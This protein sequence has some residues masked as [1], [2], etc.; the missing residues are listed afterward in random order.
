MLS[1]VAQFNLELEQIDVKTVFLHTD[2][3]ETIYIE[4]LEG[5]QVQKN[6]DIV[7]LLKKSLYGHIIVTCKWIYKIK[8]GIP[9]DEQIK[10]K[11]RLFVKGLT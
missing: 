11:A 8:R 7:C 6:K 2:L 9:E 4:Q 1:L 3:E 10:L 5:F